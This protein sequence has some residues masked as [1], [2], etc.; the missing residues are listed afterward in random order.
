MCACRASY[1]K[2]MLDLCRFFPFSVV[3]RLLY[4]FHWDAKILCNRIV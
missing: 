2:R 4:F 3:N 1:L